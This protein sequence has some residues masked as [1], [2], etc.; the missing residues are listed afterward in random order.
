MIWEIDENL[1]GHITRDEFELMYKRCR[2]DTTGLEPRSLY[3]V[4]QFLMFLQNN[5]AADKSKKKI[6]VEDTLE[7]LYVRYGRNELDK[8]IEEIFGSEEK[9]ADGQ[10]KEIS[11][12]EYLE[13][14]KKKDFKKRKELEEKRKTVN[15]PTKDDQDN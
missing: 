11:L 12:T 4:V 13:K 6:T 5:T 3:N 8:E 9:N 2:L 1:D 10:E 15:I 7:L 14:I